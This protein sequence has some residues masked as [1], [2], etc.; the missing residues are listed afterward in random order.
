MPFNIGDIVIATFGR[1]T[2]TF[3]VPVILCLINWIRGRQRA[4]LL[5][6]D[7]STYSNARLASLVAAPH[8][9]PQRTA[10]VNA[11]QTWNEQRNPPDPPD[12]P[13]NPPN[14]HIQHEHN[15]INN[16]VHHAPEHDAPEHPPPDNPIDIDDAPVEPPLQHFVQPPLEPPLEPPA[17][18]VIE[19]YDDDVPLNA[20]APPPQMYA[21][22][23]ILNKSCV[24]CCETPDI[25]DNYLC[26]SGCCICQVCL[27]TYSNT[28]L[29]TI[30]TTEKPKCPMQ[31]DGLFSWKTLANALPDTSFKQIYEHY[32]ST[33]S[34]S[35]PALKSFKETRKQHLHNTSEI[36]NMSQTLLTPCCHL[37]FYEFQDCFAVQCECKKWFCAWCMS[38]HFVFDGTDEAHQHVRICDENPRKGA[39]YGDYQQWDIH[40]AK[41]KRTRLRETRQFIFEEMNKWP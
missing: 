40:C 2:R 34:T 5:T 22:I 13:N 20:N 35:Q 4:T 25:F 1:G 36:L 27:N 24:I 28:L 7:G 41:K 14:P 29:Q 23:N 32:L 8:D 30:I 37:P 17:Q 15:P 12:P 19:I 6:T 11:L 9:I 38:P 16:H 26:S 39:V 10:L 21:P 31:C 3:K 18:V 33:S